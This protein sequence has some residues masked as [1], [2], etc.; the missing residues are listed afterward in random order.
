MRWSAHVGAR[1]IAQLLLTL[2]TLLVH[3][4]RQLFPKSS[5]STPCLA[6]NVSLRDSKLM[7]SQDLVKVENTAQHSPT[8][9]RKL[10]AAATKIMESSLESPVVEPAGP[11]SYDRQATA[12]RASFDSLGVPGLREL[13]IAH[14][15]H[16]C[17]GV[18]KAAIEL[19]AITPAVGCVEDSFASQNRDSFAS[20]KLQLLLAEY[21]HDP[22]P[23][24]RLSALSS[25]LSMQVHNIELNVRLF[26]FA[27]TAAKATEVDPKCRLVAVELMTALAH[28]HPHY[29]V[30][31]VRGAAV[32]LAD[33]VCSF[34]FSVPGIFTTLCA[35]GF[36]QDM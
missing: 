18:R 17:P 19:L 35:S 4:S 16:P 34:I 1:L 6:V 3:S 28:L 11:S 36:H 33:E 12:R 10:A 29:P 32:T 26:P 30:A 8:K 31:Y 27:A 21:L 24:V 23:S 2:R 13:V 14:L 5:S 22:H 7:R 25:I 15:G 20:D 9:R